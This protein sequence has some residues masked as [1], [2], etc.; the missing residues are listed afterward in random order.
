MELRPS[1]VPLRP[2]L[3]NLIGTAV[4]RLGFTRIE[5]RA[6]SYDYKE[7]FT[8]YVHCYDRINGLDL[9]FRSDMRALPDTLS[10]M[11]FLAHKLAF[12]AQ[13]YTRQNDR[14]ANPFERRR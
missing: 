4:A 10:A 1:L 3:E 7:T 8:V 5:V 14:A 9:S 2:S 13:I 11:E 12:K 6:L